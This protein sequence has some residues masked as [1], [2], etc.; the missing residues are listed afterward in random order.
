MELGSFLNVA[1]SEF[2][3]FFNFSFSAAERFIDF[4]DVIESDSLF[5]G[6]GGV[7]VA[8]NAEVNE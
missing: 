6:K 4:I 3:I 8:W 5:I 2:Q 7:D 1:F